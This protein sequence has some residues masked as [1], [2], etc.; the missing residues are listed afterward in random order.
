MQ[1]KVDGKIGT[2]LD[3]NLLYNGESL[4]TY[5]KQYDMGEIFGIY[6]C[7]LKVTDEYTILHNTDI[8]DKIEER[9]K[10]YRKYKRDVEKDYTIYRNDKYFKNQADIAQLE[11]VITLLKDNE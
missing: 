6:E 9:M 8:I 5:T 4:Y 3:F 11:W 10:S 7:H 2:L 1:R